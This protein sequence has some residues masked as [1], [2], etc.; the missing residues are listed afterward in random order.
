MRVLAFGSPTVPQAGKPDLS[1]SSGLTAN[2]EGD[3]S[4]MSAIRP[5][6]SAPTSCDRPCAIAGLI[7]HFAR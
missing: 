6:V 3:Q 4:T 5:G 1:T 2:C 7:V